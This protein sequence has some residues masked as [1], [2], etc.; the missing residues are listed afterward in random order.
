MGGIFANA[1][2][3][4]QNVG[5]NPF[6]FQ[7]YQLADFP[8]DGKILYT[9]GTD[10]YW[11]DAVSSSGLISSGVIYPE[12]SITDNGDGTLTIGTSTVALHS[13]TNFSTDLVAYELASTTL[14]PTVGTDYVIVAEYN[15]G[16]PR[17]VLE[18]DSST[19]SG[20]DRVPVY[21][22]IR[23]GEDV[24]HYVSFNSLGSGLA[25]QNHRMLFLTGRFRISELGGFGL[26]ETSTPV[27]RTVTIGSGDGFYASV[28]T[29][30]DAFN[31]S[32]DDFFFYYNDTGVWTQSTTTQYN[33][34]QYDDGT[35]LVNLDL[36]KYGVVWIYR[37]IET[38]AHGY[39]VLGSQQYNTVA[40]AKLSQ[41]RGDLPDLIK[42]HTF[43][44][45]RIIVQLNASTGVVEQVAGATTFAPSS[46]QNHNDLANIQG[47]SAGE[48]Y[49]ITSAEATVVGNTSG[50]NTGDVSLAGSYDYITISDQIITRN[51]IDLSTDITG[52]L[53]LDNGGTA[54]S[55]PRAW[56]VT[57]ASTSPAFIQGGL[58]PVPDFGD[59]YTMSRITC[60]VVG[61][62]SKV[63]AI[64]DGSANSTEDITCGTT[65]TSDDGSITNASFTGQEAK[66][67]DF[68][69]TTGDVNYVTITVYK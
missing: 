30:L 9:D 45:G 13:D 21:S 46:V 1:V 4:T 54:T 3:E 41:P 8:V 39:M 26:G 27:A 60:R 16:S 2:N 50:T 57:V 19:V 17:Y 40:A 63:I 49:H 67:I 58:L 66:Y 47:G 10:N 33:N 48:Y 6:T 34:T 69:A 59:A 38:V 68:G 56:S 62:T 37:G 29:E 65:L 61:G 7:S 52:V 24:I 42:Y 53:P 32:S 11:D 36:N 14:T 22:V 51:Q 31:S 44:V 35:D 55:S 43:L 5:T 20:S 23:D 25:N 12:P 28:F 18:S 64:E 15:S